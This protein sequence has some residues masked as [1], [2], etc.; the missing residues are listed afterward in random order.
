M[1]RASRQRRNLPFYCSQRGPDSLND[2]SSLAACTQR[3]SL[4]L[5]EGKQSPGPP[6]IA[7]ASPPIESARHCL[8]LSVHSNGCGHL[9]RL[10]GLEGQRQRAEAGDAAAC[11]PEPHSSVKALEPTRSKK[12]LKGAPKKSLASC[13]RACNPRPAP[14][15]AAQTS[16][17]SGAKIMA[18]MQ[19]LCRCLRVHS[20]SVE[21]AST[22]LGM[23]YRLLHAAAAGCTWYGAWGFALGRGVFG[24]GR[25]QWAQAADYV[26]DASLKDLL[27]DL[28]PDDGGWSREARILVRWALPMAVGPCALAAVSLGQVLTRLL[29]FL[30]HPEEAVQFCHRKCVEEAALRCERAAAGEG[31]GLAALSTPVADRKT[32]PCAEDGSE[33]KEV[34]EQAP[35]VQARPLKRKSGSR[36]PAAFPLGSTLRVYSKPSR[37]WYVCEVVG[38][39]SFDGAGSTV[40]FRSGNR[41]E[42]MDLDAARVQ[43]VRKGNGT[44]AVLE[45]KAAAKTRPARNG[46]S[47]E[48]KGNVL[49]NLV[50]SRLAKTG[51]QEVEVLL[52]SKAAKEDTQPVEPVE[53]LPKLSSR[54]AAAQA[55]IT[56][57]NNGSHLAPFV[58]LLQ[59]EAG[60]REPTGEPLQGGQLPCWNLCS[61]PA[62]ASAEEAPA[63]ASKGRSKSAKAKGAKAKA[64]SRA[65]AHA[66][67]LLREPELSP[68][69]RAL[70]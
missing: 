8:H 2:P 11:A 56:A 20:V 5:P 4:E 10:N 66:E 12:E 52:G 43:L 47:E 57:A 16:P 39:G 37:T 46:K 65:P 62:G 28:R 45:Q 69:Q 60:E 44:S 40:R 53:P 30:A 17:L 51:Q 42:E 61:L 33:A 63:A 67:P 26:A 7:G 36:L 68:E 48:G 58:S 49:A 13:P 23:P 55:H 31:R 38:E 21:D 41:V 27:H 34:R 14:C 54:G 25:E 6:P 32:S 29:R 50:G 59:L 70:V 64:A 22:K 18:L 3:A 1:G 19:E 9:N 15:P 24:Q 35:V